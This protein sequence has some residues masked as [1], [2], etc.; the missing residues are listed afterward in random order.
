MALGQVEVLL[1]GDGWR[2]LGLR[3]WLLETG[4]GSPVW[5]M[6]LHR[7][8]LEL[9]VDALCS[10]LPYWGMPLT[11]PGPVPAAGT[12]RSGKRHRGRKASPAGR[13]D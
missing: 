11:L 8:R 7:E 9:V 12:R 5:E 3:A 10:T 4:G 6:T 13:E 1:N 2:V